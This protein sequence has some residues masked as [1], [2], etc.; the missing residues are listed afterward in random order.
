MKRIALVVLASAVIT[1]CGT[2]T[3][4]GNTAPR[5][6]VD[7]HPVFIAGGI[8]V[9]G[10]EGTPVVLQATSTLDV[11][12][13]PLAV[14]WDFG[15]GSPTAAASSSTQDL[16]VT[17][18][19]PDNTDPY[20]VAYARVTDAQGATEEIRFD[21]Y[22]ANV[23]PSATLVA[24][25][26]VNA[27]SSFTVQLESPYDPSPVDLAAGLSYAFDCDDGNGMQDAASASFACPGSAPGWRTVTAS[28]SDKDGGTFWQTAY[29]EIVDACVAPGA[30]TISVPADP[31][32]VGSTVSAVVTF[33]DASDTGTTVDVV[34]SDGVHGTAT[35]ANGTAT[36]TRTFAS[37]GV[38][39]ATA[40]VTNDCGTAS[41]STTGYVV[42]YDPSAGFVTGGGW[43]DAAPGSFSANPALSGKTT[44][45]FVAKYQ[46]GASVPTG[47]TEFQFHANGLDFKSIAYEWLVIAGSRAQYKGTGT[48]KGQS[49][50]FSFLLTAIDGGPGGANDAMRMKILDANGGVVFD[51]K[52]GA[53]D[54]GNDAT[55]LD[56]GSISIKKQ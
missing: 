31:V 54:A 3:V 41:A 26:S 45:G 36:V 12:S 47:H 14:E 27:G 8:P 50:T 39:T 9:F 20:Y 13:A 10:D 42:V 46:K 44:F 33:A 29:V 1:G 7:A 56:G 2:D 15:D 51:N 24:P 28:V 37:A 6:P 35:P 21:V 52:Q 38:Y 53:S 5:V 25:T 34:W 16:S 18:T 11:S 4:T 43:I 23:D 22:I 49:G 40:T 30:A 48:I 17:H 55:Q 32:Q 19:W